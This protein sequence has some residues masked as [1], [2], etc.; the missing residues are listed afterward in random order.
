MNLLSLHFAIKELDWWP[1]TLYLF[2]FAK[3]CFSYKMAEIK[4]SFKNM[5][6]E[7]DK[8]LQR[9]V[10]SDKNKNNFISTLFKFK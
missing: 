10:F 6:E 5:Q 7:N 9:E 3:S 2:P 4:S 8:P 1:C